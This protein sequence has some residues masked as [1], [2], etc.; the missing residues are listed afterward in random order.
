MLA[1]VTP[2]HDE[3]WDPDFAASHD[4]WRLFSLVDSID[5]GE[6]VAALITDLGLTFSLQAVEAFRVERCIERSEAHDREVDF[7][8]RKRYEDSLTTPS[9]FPR[10]PYLPPSV[11]EWVWSPCSHGM[12]YLCPRILLH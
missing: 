11:T 10:V 1:L 5:N 7:I 8:W 3:N 9:L 12:Y 4:K 6:E 2:T